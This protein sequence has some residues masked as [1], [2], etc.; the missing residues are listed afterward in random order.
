MNTEAEK[1]AKA[2]KEIW[3]KRLAYINNWENVREWYEVDLRDRS[4]GNSIETV[5]V[6]DSDK[7]WDYV[8][9]YNLKNVEGYNTDYFVNDFIGKTETGL[10]AD[11]YLI[12]EYEKNWYVE[13]YNKNKDEWEKEWNNVT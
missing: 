7:A 1:F 5:L 4:T 11:A 9:K 8:A 6:T 3:E 13:L 10:I 2:T 12:D